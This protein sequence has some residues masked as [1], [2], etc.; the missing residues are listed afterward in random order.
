MCSDNSSTLSGPEVVCA[1]GS[2]GLHDKLHGGTSSGYESM[3]RESEGTV[4]EDDQ[5][6]S[7]SEHSDR[8]KGS[9]KKGKEWILY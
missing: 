2:R 7:G 5:E 3:L 8:R 6:D 4:T 1:P 9:K